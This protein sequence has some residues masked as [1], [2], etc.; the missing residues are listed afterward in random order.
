MKA[1]EVN[2][3]SNRFPGMEKPAL[4]RVGFTLEQ[5]ECLGIVGGSGSGKGAA[6]ER[7]P[8]RFGLGKDGAHTVGVEEV[9][10]RLEQAAGCVF[11]G[12]HVDS[13]VHIL[14]SV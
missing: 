4:N 13:W 12:G 7:A 8:A 6:E 9:L 3:V 5:G 10:R 11:V 1:L 2:G 14:I